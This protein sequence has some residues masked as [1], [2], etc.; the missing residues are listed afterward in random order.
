MLNL[1]PD[2]LAREIRAS[3]RRI[4]E[5]IEPWKKIRKAYTGRAWSNALHE[6]ARAEQF[7]F[8]FIT[9]TIAKLAHQAPRVRVESPRGLREVLFAENMERGCN[10]WAKSTRLDEPLEELAID[11]MFGPALAYLE[12]VPN[13]DMHLS[14]EDRE[15]LGGSLGRRQSVEGA[16]NVE[17][18]T[19]PYFARLRRLSLMDAGWDQTAKTDSK[20]RYFYHKVT[21]DLD[22]LKKKAEEA[23]DEWYG[24]LVNRLQTVSDHRALGYSED[25]G[26]DTPDRDQVTY[27]VMHVVDAEIDGEERGDDESGVIFTLTSDVNDQGDVVGEFLRPPYYGYG[28]TNGGYIK[29]DSYKVPES[30]WSLGPLTALFDKTETL[31]DVR[32]AVNK[33]IIAYRRKVIADLKDKKNIERLEAGRDDDIVLLE[34][35]DGK[36]IAQLE[37]A[38]AS[39]Q[40]LAHLQYLEDEL[41]DLA[42]L[43]D[44]SRGNVSGAG[45]AT[46]NTLAAQAAE[47]R[48]GF[49]QGKWLKG[50]A[51]IFQRFMWFLGHDD[52]IVFHY[53]VDKDQRESYAQSMMR[54]EA[55]KAAAMADQGRAQAHMEAVEAEAARIIEA[56][57]VTFQGGDAK[58][59]RSIGFDSLMLDIEPY[60]MQKRDQRTR[61][62]DTVEALNLLSQFAGQAVQGVPIDLGKVADMLADVYE[63]PEL[64]GAVNRQ[65]AKNMGLLAI[66]ERVTAIEA[67]QAA[68]EGGGAPGQTQSTRSESAVPQGGGGAGVQRGSSAMPERMAGG[69]N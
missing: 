69:V 43:A 21:E 63:M 44:F 16:E 59:D 29:I 14:A 54:V 51:A 26:N 1:D 22:S 12:E 40:D 50:V 5:R 48:S 53:R 39:P 10:H 36:D 57:V 55:E 20:I 42:G 58:A 34:A 19:A 24:E 64:E 37:L 66:E 41:A 65:L 11:V 68:P 33:R 49:F 60:S 31:N 18:E 23:P 8:S 15:S 28:P 38:G 3:E 17:N 30:T 46:E 25:A 27:Y 45:T 13:E 6:T 62:M 67:G 4:Q 56:G 61:K 47:S 9:T 32:A 7:A 52:R 35:F 2:H